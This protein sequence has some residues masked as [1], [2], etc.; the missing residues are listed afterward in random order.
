LTHAEPYEAYSSE[1]P[2]DEL[3][4]ESL[5]EY[6]ECDVLIVCGERS[7]SIDAPHGAVLAERL[8]KGRL[9]VLTGLGHFGPQ[10]DP[11]ACAASIVAFAGR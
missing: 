3:T 11:D 8:P 2:L 4:P 1:P 6:V 9:E 5:H 7:S 10:Q